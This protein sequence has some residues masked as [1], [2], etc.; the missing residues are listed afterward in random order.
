MTY[1]DQLQLGAVLVRCRGCRQPF[2]MTHPNTK[3]I[4][5][6]ASEQRALFDR[7]DLRVNRTETAPRCDKMEG[8]TGSP[9]FVD[10]ND[11]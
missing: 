1:D 11:P 10:A 9:A 4:R 5:C 3:C 2:Y 7:Q 6:R 8:K